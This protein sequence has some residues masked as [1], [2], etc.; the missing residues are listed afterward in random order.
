VGA[1]VNPQPFRPVLRGVLLTGSSP[2][3]LRS[4]ISGDAGDDSTVAADALW[5]P[6]NKLCGRYLAPYLSGQVGDAA[7]VMPQDRH[8]VRV[9][10]APGQR[11]C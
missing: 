2:R 8:A 1:D 11:S 4:D 5:W 6:P 7:D 9:E 10:A 3:F